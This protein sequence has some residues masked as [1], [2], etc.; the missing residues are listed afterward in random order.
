MN[1]LGPVDLLG[2]AASLGRGLSFL[3]NNLVSLSE[4]PVA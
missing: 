2:C 3:C 4:G 1:P